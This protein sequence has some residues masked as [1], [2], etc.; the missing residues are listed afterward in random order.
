MRDFLRDTY[1]PQAQGTPDAVGRERYARFA[2]RWN[3]SD[4]GAGTGL[5]DAYAW[6]WAEHRRIREEQRAA[7]ELV[8]PGA[9]RWRPCAGSAS[10]ARPWTASRRSGSGCRR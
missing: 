1:L 6:G 5:E 8:R 7:A 3:G 2:R 9:T 4:L 10:T